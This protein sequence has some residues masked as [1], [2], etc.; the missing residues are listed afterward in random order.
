MRG[1]ACRMQPP[2]HTTGA[3]PPDTRPRL[4]QGYALAVVVLLLA[5]AAV[6]YYAHS[7]R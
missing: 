7:R 1:Y 2:G 6:F 3:T 4:R 5:L